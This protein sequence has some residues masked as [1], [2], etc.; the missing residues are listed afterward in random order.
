MTRERR[1]ESL[2]EV[3]GMNKFI[4]VFNEETAKILKS[5]GYHCIRENHDICYI[6]ANKDGAESSD[7]VN[8]VKGTYSLV[9]GKDYS[10]S[11]ECI[12]TF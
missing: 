1:T 10:L 11:N 9:S 3:T 2:S 6:F 7:I 12:L 8:S 5:L 4:Y